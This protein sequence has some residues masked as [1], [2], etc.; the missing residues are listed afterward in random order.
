VFDIAAFLLLPPPICQL[1]NYSE[2]INGG[3]PGKAA[4]KEKVIV[5]PCLHYPPS[6]GFSISKKF[7]LRILTFLPVKWVCM[8]IDFDCFSSH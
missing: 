8:A 3:F 7:V 2:K 5:R 6:C 4:V 1:S